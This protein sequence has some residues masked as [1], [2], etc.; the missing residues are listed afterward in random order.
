MRTVTLLREGWQF[1]SCSWDGTHQTLPTGQDWVDVTLP[2]VWNGD[3]PKQEGP[4]L[5]RCTLTLADAA[6]PAFV[7]F[8]AVAGIC[9]AWLNGCYLGCH[10]GGYARFR[11]ALT[12]AR[13]GSNELLVLPD[14]THRDYI[15]LGGD[16]NNYGGIYRP[17]HLI[18]TGA[19]HFD[20]LYYGTSGLTA[21]PSPDGKVQ[22]SA[23]IAGPTE[24][25]QIQYE[26]LDQGDACAC[27][28][29]PASAPQACLQVSRPHSWDGRKDPYLYACRARLLR[30]GGL[31]PQ[32]PAPEAAG[33]RQTSGLGGLP[34]RGFRGTAAA[35][36]PAVLR[37]GGQRGASVPLPAPRPDL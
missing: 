10:K 16:F 30:D 15:P 14:N 11:F 37:D 5:Y 35:G 25:V 31:F 24:G 27:V 28:T 33:R 17:V 19:T 6:R 36:H 22:V 32:R 3:D 29:C 13:T 4:R 23:R 20:L 7:D 1:S 12:G 8:G 2:H 18:Q 21:E 9:H 26:V 34:L